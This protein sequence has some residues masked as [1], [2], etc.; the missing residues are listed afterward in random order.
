MLP[1]LLLR[2]EALELLV[3]DPELLLELPPLYELEPLLL[4][5]ELLALLPL[6][7][8]FL[9]MPFLPEF[10]PPLEFPKLGLVE[11][12][13]FGLVFVLGEFVLV[14]VFV[15]GLAELFAFTL[16][17]FTPV[18][19]DRVGRV[20][21]TFSVSPFEIALGFKLT[22]LSGDFSKVKGLTPF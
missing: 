7:D 6:G 9:F 17:V 8:L 12:I 13:L 14:D 3:E 20:V 2:P 21:L 19:L 11:E 15:P 5:S 1:A 18:G 16:P 22:L 4:E 10:T